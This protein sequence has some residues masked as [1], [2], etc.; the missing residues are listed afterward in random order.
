M[1]FFPHLHENTVFTERT[2]IDPGLVNKA[3]RW[4]DRAL[5][6][7]H[8]LANGKFLRRRKQNIAAVITSAGFDESGLLELAEYRLKKSRWDGL[9]LG[10]ISNLFWALITTF[11]QLKNS[12]QSI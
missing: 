1:N 11:S 3:A 6:K 4:S 10:D 9:G 2:F 7:F 12:P 8:Y 5:D